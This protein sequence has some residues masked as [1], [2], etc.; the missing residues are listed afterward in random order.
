MHQEDTKFGKNNRGKSYNS[1]KACPWKTQSSVK[2][3]EVPN[4][5]FASTRIAVL[6]VAIRSLQLNDREELLS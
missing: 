5:N 2:K 4:K 1:I 6:F 3:K